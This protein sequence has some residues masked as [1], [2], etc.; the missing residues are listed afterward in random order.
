MLLH[1]CYGR[2]KQRVWTSKIS[3][4][5]ISDIT[6]KMYRS[7][8]K[9]IT[10]KHRPANGY[11][12]CHYLSSKKIQL[13]RPRRTYTTSPSDINTKATK[14]TLTVTLTTNVEHRLQKDTITSKLSFS[15]AMILDKKHGVISILSSASISRK[16]KSKVAH[17]RRRTSKQRQA[18]HATHL[19]MFLRLMQKS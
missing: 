12:Y 5:S 3:T 10:T 8:T 11:Y 2:A 19:Q 1:T 16:L 15:K 4:Y 17:E 14:H 7:K 18:S 13:R 6:I 9:R